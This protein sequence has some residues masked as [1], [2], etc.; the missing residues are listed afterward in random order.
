MIQRHIKRLAVWYK[1]W[2]LQGGS[3]DRK[4]CGRDTS[5]H[6]N[7]YKDIHADMQLQLNPYSNK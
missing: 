6:E 1:T 3:Y 5:H 7:T 4:Q 2:K